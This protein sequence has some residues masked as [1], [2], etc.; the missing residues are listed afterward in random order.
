MDWQYRSFP[1]YGLLALILV[2]TS[3]GLFFGPSYSISLESELRTELFTTNEYEVL[4]RPEKNVVISISM[5]ILTINDLN[6]KDQALSISGYLT[7]NWR[8]SRLDWSDPANTTQDYRSIDFLFSNEEYVWRPSIIIE[9][10][11]QDMGV[12]SDKSTPMRITHM[13][14]VVWSPSGIFVVSCESDTTYYPLDTQEC[15]V[16]VSSKAYTINEV[17]LMLTFNPV[18]LDFYSKNG[19]WDL[20][21]ASGSDVSDTAVGQSSFS[22]VDFDIKLR[23]RPVFHIIN[24]LFPVVMMAILIAMVFKLPVDSG[25]RNGFALTVLLAY[26]V[27]LSIISENI[28]STSVSV[29]FLSLYLAFVLFLAVMSVVLTI[30]VLRAHYGT[31][32]IPKLLKIVFNCTSRSKVDV[33]ILEKKDVGEYKHEENKLTWQKVAVKMDTVFFYVYVLLISVVT[34]VLTVA[35][36]IHYRSI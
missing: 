36:I 22:S 32:K 8:D 34:S 1:L 3:F 13:G 7:F 11:I 15:K 28:P 24:T 16:K 23:R 9:N 25:E 29:C 12:I 27:Y 14:T 17:S 35:Y 18:I 10:S 5:T 6:I 4:Q 2:P 30:F 31:G 21:S 19:E 20:V 33:Q 26:A